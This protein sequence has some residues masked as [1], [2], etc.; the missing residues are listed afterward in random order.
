MAVPAR[1]EP[2]LSLDEVKES[3]TAKGRERGFVT[4]E[5]L[6]EAVPVDDFTPEQVEEFL[7]Q[8]GDQGPHLPTEANLCRSMA[9][10]VSGNFVPCPASS[11]DH[12]SATGRVE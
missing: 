9:E 1:D 4:S 10:V 12:S 5:D 8:V 6:L 11:V 7:T 2:P 3:I